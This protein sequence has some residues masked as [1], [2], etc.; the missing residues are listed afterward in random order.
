MEIVGDMHGNS[1]SRKAAK[2][3]IL[4]ARAQHVVSPA[5]N[6]VL[7]SGGGDVGA[8]RGFARGNSLAQTVLNRST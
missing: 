3:R 1:A 7:M 8:L 5:K 2:R 4:L 6:S